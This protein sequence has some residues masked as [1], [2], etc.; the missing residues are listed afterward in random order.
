MD[1]EK[2]LRILLKVLRVLSS[3]NIVVC[4]LGIILYKLNE[5]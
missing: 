5:K 2:R 4:M 3:A 1:V